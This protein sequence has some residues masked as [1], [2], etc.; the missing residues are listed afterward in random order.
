MCQTLNWFVI[1][2]CVKTVIEPSNRVQSKTVILNLIF[3][4][5][6]T[7][8]VQLIAPPPRQGF[9][10][11]LKNFTGWGF[12]RFFAGPRVVPKK[13][14]CLSNV[15]HSHTSI[16]YTYYIEKISRAPRG[17]DVSKN[18]ILRQK[19]ISRDVFFFLAWE[20]GGNKLDNLGNNIV[21]KN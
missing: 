4:I 20:G 10:R 18:F 12:E 21:W 1:L 19:T 16:K 8:V 2:Q 5:G 3:A 13:I 9:R 15:R 7:Q 17:N 14:S 11:F 6:L